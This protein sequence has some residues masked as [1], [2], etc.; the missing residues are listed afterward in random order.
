LRYELS[1][2]VE[3][4]LRLISSA[5]ANCFLSSFSDCLHGNDA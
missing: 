5:W 3:L 1:M 2:N 4:V